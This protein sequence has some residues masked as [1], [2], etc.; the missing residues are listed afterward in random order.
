MDLFLDTT[1]YNPTKGKLSSKEDL[2]LSRLAEKIPGIAQ[3]ERAFTTFLNQQRR[4]VFETQA[5]KWIRRG[6]T[7][8]IDE[9][10][11]KQLAT[12]LHHAT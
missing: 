8:A 9:K 1:F 12:F 10:S 11:F 7:P 3:S 4:L 6:I 5:K 2:Y